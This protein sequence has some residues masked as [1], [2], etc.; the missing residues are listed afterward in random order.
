MIHEAY[1]RS[2]GL[3]ER[4]ENSLKIQNWMDEKISS[5]KIDLLGPALPITGVQ[6]GEL[7]KFSA[8][9]RWSEE[10]QSIHEKDLYSI[11]LTVMSP[12]MNKLIKSEEVYVFHK[13]AAQGQ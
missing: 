6:E 8:G 11:R 2:A 13:D 4:Y 12:G 9:F 5:D 7:A 3:F 1:L 10:V